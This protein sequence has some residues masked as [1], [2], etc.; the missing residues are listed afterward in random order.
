VSA[1]FAERYAQAF[2]RYAAAG[3]EASL[4]AAYELGRSAV[5]DGMSVLD[6]AA[7]HHDALLAPRDDLEATV[8]AGGEFF[9]EALSAFEMVQRA[10]QEA[11][12]E[13]AVERRQAGVLR[14]LSTFL[15]DASIAL[16]ASSSLGEMLQLVAE[17]AREVVGA[18]RCRVRLTSVDDAPALEAEACAEPATDGAGVDLEALYSAIAPPGGSVR[19]TAAELARHP[20]LEALDPD[21][22]GADARRGWLAAPLT[23]LDGRWLGL[24]QLF[25]KQ[26]GEFTELDEAVLVQLAQMSSAAVERTRLYRG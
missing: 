22:D 4:S 10:L 12:E 17:H 11:G 7:A 5:R 13:A 3:D 15:G 14:Q 24:I 8:R 18:E 23:A 1:T 9:M 16:D 21:G 20:A 2:E 19:M 6:L 26:G 25:G